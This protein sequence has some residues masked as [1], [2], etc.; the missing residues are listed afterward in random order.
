MNVQI[1]FKC[2]HGYSGPQDHAPVKCS[3]CGKEVRNRPRPLSDEDKQERGLL[4]FE[5]HK[6]GNCDDCW[7]TGRNEETSKPCA[8]GRRPW[9]YPDSGNWSAAARLFNKLR[10]LRDD[11][12]MVWPDDD[13]A[14]RAIAVRVTQASLHGV[15]VAAAVLLVDRD[16][17]FKAFTEQT[18]RT[19]EL[20]RKLAKLEPS[21]DA[22]EQA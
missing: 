3:M 19:D 9:K 7:G 12:L 10:D 22:K 17:F 13:D 8:C 21:E 1:E 16:R 20:A 14:L 2:G 6:W 5:T 18:L 15:D 11:G 4:A